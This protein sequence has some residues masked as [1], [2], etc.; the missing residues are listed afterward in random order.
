MNRLIP[1]IV[2]LVGAWPSAGL[3]QLTAAM[4]AMRTVVGTGRVHCWVRLWS[5]R[6]WGDGLWRP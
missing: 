6:G 1:G 3:Q 5:R 2:L 4:A